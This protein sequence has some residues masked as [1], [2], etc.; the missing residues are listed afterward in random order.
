MVAPEPLVGAFGGVGV[1]CGE[2]ATPRL[3]SLRSR[4]KGGRPRG[5][6]RAVS[7]TSVSASGGADDG[8]AGAVQRGGYG[9]VK[10]AVPSANRAQWSSVVVKPC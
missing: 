7:T 3:I 4:S 6:C 1:V 5:P 2:S 10:A 9:G 8:V